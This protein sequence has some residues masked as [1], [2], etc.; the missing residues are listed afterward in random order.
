VGRHR[1]ADAGYRTKA[2]DHGATLDIDVGVT[3]RDP[4]QKGFE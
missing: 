4:A 1:R 2:I 3:R